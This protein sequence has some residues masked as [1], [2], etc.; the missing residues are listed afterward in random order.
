MRVTKV[1]ELFAAIFVILLVLALG[2]GA[3][4]AMGKRVPVV[5]DLLGM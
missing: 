4:I 1:R 3:L 5:S 2:I